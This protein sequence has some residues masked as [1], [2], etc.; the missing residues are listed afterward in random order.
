MQQTLAAFP[1]DPEKLS[2]RANLLRC[3]GEVDAAAVVSLPPSRASAH[4]QAA[5]AVPRNTYLIPLLLAPVDGSLSCP[6]QLFEKAA[7]LD[8]TT[9]VRYI[10]S[11][12]QFLFETGSSVS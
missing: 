11:F 8:D 4:R 5:F 10:A 9:D 12:A 3:I 2:R 7:E 6:L 1:T